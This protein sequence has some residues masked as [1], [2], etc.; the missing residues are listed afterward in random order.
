MI[1]IQ[2]ITPTTCI[3]DSQG[4]D[5]A[6]A[7]AVFREVPG[8]PGYVAG[9]NGSV[10]SCWT[11]QGVTAPDRQWRCLKPKIHRKG[12]HRVSLRRDGRGRL[13]FVHAIVL[14]SF[15]GPRPPDLECRH[16]DRDPSNNSIGNILWGTREENYSDRV[17]HGTD[18]R[19]ARNRGA[20]LR[21]DDVRVIRS[22][23]ASGTH[24]RDLAYRFSVTQ[25][26]IHD[27]VYGRTWRHL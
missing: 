1:A 16:R 10:W 6:W 17:K 26:C 15:V 25:V 19:G 23:F 27:I 5:W 11:F 21:E 8:Y 4:H 13:M 20:K 9:S 2:D 18:N 22:L 14:E 24:W 7:Y 12:Y 3:L